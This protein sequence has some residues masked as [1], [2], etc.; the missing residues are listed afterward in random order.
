MTDR[1]RLIELIKN[2]LSA[3][4]KEANADCKPQDF[5]AD[6]ILANGVIVPKI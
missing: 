4:G 6:F 2:A 3:Y 1:D 5:I